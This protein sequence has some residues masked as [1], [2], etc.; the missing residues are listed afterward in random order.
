MS[1]IGLVIFTALDYGCGEDQ[2]R[3]LSTDLESL[4]D[5]LASEDNSREEDDEG[6]EHDQ[7]ILVRTELCKRVMSVCSNHLAIESEAQTHFKAVCRALV[8][9]SLEL[10]N[11]MEKVKK[12]ETKSDCKE[13]QE[14]GMWLMSSLYEW[15][16]I[17]P[18]L[19]IK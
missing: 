5:L 8:S 16:K 13:L 6:I 1:G 4:L 12:H 11:F 14:L 2:E 17:F 15:I 18:N 7:D 9:E 10:S 3:V 19:N